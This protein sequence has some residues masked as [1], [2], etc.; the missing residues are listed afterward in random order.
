MPMDPELCQRLIRAGIDPQL[1][2]L[3]RRCRTPRFITDYADGKLTWTC[4]QPACVAL[5]SPHLISLVAIQATCDACGDPGEHALAELSNGE[6]VAT[7]RGCATMT[8]MEA[9]PHA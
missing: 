5:G 9:T 8:L 7:C 1:A 2:R 3:C 4:Q 6:L